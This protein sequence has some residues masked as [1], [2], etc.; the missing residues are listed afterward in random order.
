MRATALKQARARAGLSQVEL[1]KLLRVAPST[2]AGWELG[3]HSVRAKRLS[4]LARVL[5]V[6]V[7]ELLS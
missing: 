4:Q 7:T 6:K 5:R 3:T 1:A 2:V